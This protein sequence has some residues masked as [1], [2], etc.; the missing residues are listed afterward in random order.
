MLAAGVLAG[1]AAMLAVP[2]VALAAPA[3]SPAPSASSPAATASQIP[4]GS[5]E[6]CYTVIAKDDP[7]APTTHVV[8]QGC[9]NTSTS[10]ALSQNGLSASS[11]APLVTFY[12]NEDYGG[13]S[14][15]IYGD[16]GPC[17]ASGYGIPDL[18]YTND[19]VVN[20]ISSYET[21]SSCWGQKYWSI[22]SGYNPYTTNGLCKTFTNTWQVPYVG[23]ACNDKLYSMFLWDN[24][25]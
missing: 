7:P 10:A 20:G 24:K 16:N 18:S 22:L 12:E 5:G 2:G 4:T 8:S 13:P 23:A 11:E 17:D 25:E 1:V 3:G 9:S 21:H 14:D 19:W 15:T 6:Y